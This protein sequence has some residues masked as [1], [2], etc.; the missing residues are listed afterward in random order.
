[1]KKILMVGLHDGYA[2]F[3]RRDAD[4]EL[5]VLEEE[6]LY[7]QK[8]ATYEA[9]RPAN[10][11]LT[12]Y[13]QSDEFLAAARRWHDE[14]GFDAVAPAWEY[15]VYASGALAEALGLRWPGRRAIEAC[16]DKLQL[17]ELLS[18]TPI[19]QPRWARV[20]SAEDVADF[21]RGTPIILK[22]SNR[23]ASVGVVRID[24]AAQVAAAWR[25]CVS[26]DEER[27]VA[28]RP[29]AVEFIA[30][31]F[32]PGYQ[33]SVET[34]VRDR[35]VIFDNVCLMLTAGGPYFPIL[36]VTVPAPIPSHEYAAAVAASHELVACLQVE[37]GMIHSEWKM[38][39]SE[40]YLIESAARVPGAFT[41]EL[42]E[43][44]YGGFNMYRAQVRNLAGLDPRLP[45]ADR[46][47]AS[48]R[49]FHPPS[50]K[51]RAIRGV[52]ALAADP[53]VFMHR[54]K[55]AQGDEVPV[56]RN[57]WQRV[58]YFAAHAPTW[59]ELDATVTRLLETVVFDVQPAAGS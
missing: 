36:S 10:I 53:A 35:E 11:L 12:K 34:L 44:A 21:H 1:M 8:P 48:V 39:G 17:R 43:R 16:T 25:E 29:R 23:H 38:L 6:S 54:L 41:A 7:K 46:S 55:V 3:F 5:Y 57:G 31:E 30:E 15:G 13:Q 24:D 45:G 59:G 27:T 22:P 50:G 40:P 26:A 42:A 52:E 18:S 9:C 19:R 2:N 20:S 51:V 32:V 49:W 58:G 14:V 33:V 56:C 47:I 37:N 28:D 4:L